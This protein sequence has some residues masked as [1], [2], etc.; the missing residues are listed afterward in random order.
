MG[1]TNLYGKAHANMLGGE[2]SGDAFAT[3]FLSDTIKYAL[4]TSTYT[5]NLD[6][7]ET[8]A[9]ITNEVTGTGYTAGGV[10]VGSKTITY[11]AANSWATTWATGTA[12]TV[13]QVVRP[14]TGNAHLYMCIVAGTSH[15]STEPTWPTGS[16]AT[17]T[18]N[19]VTWAEIG[20]GLTQIDFA[21]PQW[22]TATISG[23]K[24]GVLY[25]S[26]GTAATSPLIGLQDLD[27]PTTV[28]AGTFTVTI[29]ALGFYHFHTP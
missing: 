22:T 19:T 25:R 24:Y 13:G 11:T 9:D 20:R 4:T 3:D 7:H 28:T 6:T 21:D 5:P 17:V 29:P 8:F 26:T 27:G 10:T 12:Y 1:A 18:D 23:I 14:T 16:R 2:S 15:A